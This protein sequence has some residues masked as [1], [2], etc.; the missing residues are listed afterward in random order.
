MNCFHPSLALALAAVLVPCAALPAQ[1]LTITFPLIGFTHEVE[2]LWP[3]TRPGLSIS[4]RWVGNMVVS[5]D[6]PATKT[7]L[8]L[9]EPRRLPPPPGAGD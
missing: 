6:P 9:G 8:F 5:A 2:G 3:D 4:F 7:P 1:E